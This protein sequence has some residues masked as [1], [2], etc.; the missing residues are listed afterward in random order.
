M[1]KKR[2]VSQYSEKE[3]KKTNSL[4]EFK[5]P[6]VGDR[7]VIN[8]SVQPSPDTRRRLV[9]PSWNDITLPGNL[10]NQFTEQFETQLAGHLPSVEDRHQSVRMPEI[11]AAFDIAD[12]HIGGHWPYLATSL[13]QYG[14]H[15]LASSYFETSGSV[16]DAMRGLLSTSTTLYPVFTSTSEMTPRGLVLRTRPTYP[17]DSR[18]W[19]IFQTLSVLSQTAM[20]KRFAPAETRDIQFN[21]APPED[22]FSD[23]L[24]SIATCQINFGVPLEEC[25]YVYPISVQA[26]KIGHKHKELNRVL[27]AEIQRQT[28]LPTPDD[29][30]M[31]VLRQ[32][33]YAHLPNLLSA[34]DA[35]ASL[36][37]SRSTIQRV[38]KRNGVG[39][40]E[41]LNDLRR[42]HVL[43]YLS[44]ANRDADHHI[45][46]GF[47]SYRA[48]SK[49]CTINFGS[50]LAKL[51][52]EI[53]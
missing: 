44:R 52:K 42:E 38:L 40:K 34:E 32:H 10:R 41:I 22:A 46:L 13:W 48:L 43:I 49:F 1:C 26:K 4:M 31:N 47:P 7:T 5:A 30:T 20:F 36:N 15:V 35:A 11:L 51:L 23:T 18:H 21:I 29:N 8:D 39:F 45:A 19:G 27:F 14:S 3:A 50:P 2:L 24:R 25:H 53:D 28:E 16:A 6:F 37:V 12:Q 17:L 9:D 33:I